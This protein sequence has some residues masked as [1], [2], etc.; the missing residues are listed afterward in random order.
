VLEGMVLDRERADRLADH[1]RE[2]QR[3][4]D[5]DRRRHG[6]TDQG[7]LFERIEQ[8]T[9]VR[10]WSKKSETRN[11]RDT[12]RISE[13]PIERAYRRFHKAFI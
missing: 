3:D 13:L 12:T 8:P 4:H 9:R 7:G 11:L 5:R 10:T 1:Q 2:D 6:K